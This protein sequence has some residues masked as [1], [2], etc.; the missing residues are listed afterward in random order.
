MIGGIGMALMER[1]VLDWRDG[2]PVNAHMA[3]YLVPLNLDIQQI[4]AQMVEEDDPH[5]NPSWCERPRRNRARRD[6]SRHRQRCLSRDGHARARLA[7]SNREPPVG[8]HLMLN[9]SSEGSPRVVL[10]PSKLVRMNGRCIIMPKT[11]SELSPAKRPRYPR[12]EARMITTGVSEGS[13]GLKHRV[14]ECL[15]C[16]HIENNA[17]AS[18]PPNNPTGWLS[19]EVG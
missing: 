18:D 15:K 8:H 10:K 7:N 13:N 3:D 19:G 11:N 4:E 5:V 9:A 14:F 1:T 12:C 16:A 6:G 2:R 17:V